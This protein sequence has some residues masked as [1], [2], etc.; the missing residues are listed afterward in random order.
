V[1][2]R[3]CAPDHMGLFRGVKNRD[4]FPAAST[5]GSTAARNKPVC[6][7][8]LLR[9]HRILRSGRWLGYP[10]SGSDLLDFAH[11]A[12]EQPNCAANALTWVGSIFAIVPLSMKFSSS[13]MT[14]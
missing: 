12:V 7:D 3:S 4:V 8:V 14:R 11:C 1:R 9:D 10:A 5:D 6:S 2:Y 13:R